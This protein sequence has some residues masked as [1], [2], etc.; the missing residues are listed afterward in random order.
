MSYGDR[1]KKDT[2]NNAS[3]VHTPCDINRY[4]YTQLI[5]SSIAVYMSSSRTV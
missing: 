2:D 1:T 4:Y 5:K 3:K